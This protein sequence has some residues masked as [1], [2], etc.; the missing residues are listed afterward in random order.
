MK[1]IF[2]ITRS[3]RDTLTQFLN[4]YS[5]EQLNKIPEGY[6]NNLIWNI[7]HTVVV[8]QMLV[9]KLSGLPMMIPDEMVSKY[10]KGSKP[11][12]DFSQEEVDEIR[13]FLHET[14]N[15]SEMDFENQAFNNYIEFTVMTGYTIKNATDALHFNNYHE[16]VHLGIMMGIRKFI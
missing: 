3:N 7:G 14:I 9:Y 10:K 1:R 8:Q 16:A 15:K 13:S 11:E 12:Q 2:E 6:S 4:G 5:L